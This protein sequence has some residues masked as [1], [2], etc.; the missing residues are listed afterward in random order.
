MKKILVPLLLVLICLCLPALGEEAVT[1]ELLNEAKLPLYAADDPFVASLG[2][3]PDAGGLQVLV[4]PVKGSLQLQT[5]VMP[6]SVKNKKVIFT[7]E[8]PELVRISGSSLNGL[9]AGE[10]ILTA[11]SAQD[12][13]TVL[14]YRLLVIQRPTRITVTAPAKS[15]AV[16]QTIAL[17]AEY[18]PDTTTLKE[19]TWSSLD[20]KTATVDENGV[21]TALARGN[22]RIVAVSKDGSKIRANLSIRVVQNPEEITLDKTELTVAAGKNAMLRATV[23]PKNADDRNVLWSSTDES[24]AT[25]NNQGRVNGIALGDCEII[26]T[27]KAT[28]EVQAR[29]AVHVQQPVKKITFDEVPWVYAGESAQVTWQIEPANASNQAVTLKSSNE[30]VLTVSPD[31]TVTGVKAGEAFVSAV[32]TDGTN[33]QARIKIKVGQHVTGVSMKRHVG[34]IQVGSTNTTGAVVEPKNASNK[35]MTW[36]IDDPSIASVERLQKEPHRI[37]IT[38]LAEGETTVTGVTEDGGFST[39]MLVRVGY[40]DQSLDLREAY[41]LG[42]GSVVMHVRNVSQL[43]ITSVTAE[44]TI[45][46]VDGNPVPCNSRNDS[47]TFKMVYTRTLG[48]GATTGDS[49]WKVVDYKE[50]DSPAVANYVI[51]ITQFQI[52]NDWVETIQKRHQ[53][54]KKCPVHL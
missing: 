39:S 23:L 33:R 37:K 43:N 17:T 4:L 44:V 52:D 48:P 12:P 46:D 27:S 36:T 3:Q 34:Y 49:G 20:E 35:T 1:L 13:E 16:G 40:W 5:R 54:T 19:V 28:G 9:K 45:L 32:S 22:A 21:V 24:V 30:K 18:T 51:K 6:Q 26:C 38:G 42:D 14:R 11:A 2:A 41:V 15:V 8:N 10:T 29:A 53:P 7:A 47:G 50:P 31:G 25:V